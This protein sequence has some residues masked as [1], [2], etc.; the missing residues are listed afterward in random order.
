MNE[1]PREHWNRRYEE[2]WST[3]PSAFLLSLDD[4][5][6]RSGRALD[7]AGGNAR[8]ALWLA[9][10]G[11]DVTVV[12]V[13]DEALRRAQTVSD[14]AGV[15]LRLVEADLTK[16]PVPEGPWDLIVCFHYLQRDLFPEMISSLAPGGVLTCAIA[17]VRNLE[18]HP[19]PPR[20]YVLE[21]GELPGL[22]EGLTVL[23]YEEAW[24]DDHHEAR[25][26]GVRAAS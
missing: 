24:F 20:P 7:V 11:L 16:A 15:D 3:E 14:A 26:V 21:E 5:L 17:T 22:L 9:R 19:R 18:R 4:V 25:I 12:D 8:N 13:S 23:V 10:R 6:P 2:G 1:N